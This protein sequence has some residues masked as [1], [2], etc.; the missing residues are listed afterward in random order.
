MLLAVEA[1]N[2]KKTFKT[3]QGNV[4]AVRDVSFKVNK[5]EIF[6]ILGPNGAGKS[7]TILMLTTLLRITSGTAKIND[8]DVERNDSEVRNKIGIALQDT[9]IDN[10][11]TARELFYTTARLWGLYKISI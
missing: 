2:L 10:L 1:K 9:G 4:E 7:T 11:L 6:G 8:L 5:G 3:K